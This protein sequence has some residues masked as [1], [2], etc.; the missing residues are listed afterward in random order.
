MLGFSSLR[1]H[2][3]IYSVTFLAGERA[4]QGWILFVPTPESA[5]DGS[6]QVSWSGRIHAAGTEQP[7]DLMV[8]SQ[9]PLD[10]ARTQESTRGPHSLLPGARRAHGGRNLLLGT[11]T[12]DAA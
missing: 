1:W 5:E 10:P 11:T 3:Q 12:P 6:A 7:Q 2:L 9:V 4:F 8:P